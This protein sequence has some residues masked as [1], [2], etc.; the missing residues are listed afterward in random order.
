MRGIYLKSLS[1]PYSF[2]RFI[3]LELP[4]GCYLRFT[5]CSGV[6]VNRT[7]LFFMPL[8]KPHSANT[9]P[10]LSH[11]DLKCGTIIKGISLPLTNSRRIAHAHL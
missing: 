1:Y 9:Q 2:G 11:S 3:F 5:G 4:K 7:L 10:I 6:V 8:K